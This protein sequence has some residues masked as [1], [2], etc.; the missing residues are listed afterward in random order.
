[1]FK[2]MLPRE[3]RPGNVKLAVTTINDHGCVARE[4]MLVVSRIQE[5]LGIPK[6]SPSKL[7]LPLVNDH[8]VVLWA[9]TVAWQRRAK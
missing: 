4:S 5:L 8:Q 7:I 3:S 1:L 2:L 9:I 6:E